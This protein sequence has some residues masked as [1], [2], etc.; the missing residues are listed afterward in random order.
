MESSPHFGQ[1][2]LITRLTLV[3][4]HR[5]FNY[6]SAFLDRRKMQETNTYK[7]FS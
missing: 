3:T 4:R 7:L 1:G 2:L 5:C 6:F